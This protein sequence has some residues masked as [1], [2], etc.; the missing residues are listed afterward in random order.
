MPV[1]TFDHLIHS[2]ALRDVVA[3]LADSAPGLVLTTGGTGSGKLTTLLALAQRLAGPGQ[4]VLFV[5]DDPQ[6]IVPFAP[7]PDHWREVLVEPNAQ[8][9]QRALGGSGMPVDAIVVVAPLHALNAA[10]VL[11]AAAGRW[12]LATVDTPAIGLDVAAAVHRL[13][14]RSEAFIDSVRLVWS[15]QLVGA[16]CSACSAP[17]QL[18]AAESADL[19]PDGVPGDGVRIEVGCP[20]CQAAA[21][22]ARG[23]RGST[24]ICDA[25]LIDEQS[26]SAVR[27]AMLAGVPLPAAPAWHVAAQ[28]QVHELVAQGVIGVGTLRNVIARNP[29][30]RARNT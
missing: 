13:G 23:T 25:T 9:W 11:S 26:R 27:A 20:V 2:Q 3:R 19:F 29:S 7:L 30:L 12:L 15:Q 5:T 1:L 21:H 17:A 14:V 28:D 24:A 8:A 10:A 22:A 16:L 6:N 18:S 4:E